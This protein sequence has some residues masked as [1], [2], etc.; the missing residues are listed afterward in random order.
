M[1]FFLSLNKVTGYFYLLR[2][3]GLSKSFEENGENL[4]H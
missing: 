2:V 3:E 4:S 1:L